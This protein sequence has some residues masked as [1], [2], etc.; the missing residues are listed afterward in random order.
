MQYGTGGVGRHPVVVGA[1]G[2]A[3]AGADE[4]QVLDAGD[5]ARVGTVQP[6]AGVGLGIER[7]QG[8]VGG[9]PC[10]QG[11]VLGLAAVA[12]VDAVGLRERRDVGDPLVQC[13]QAAAVRGFVLRTRDGIHPGTP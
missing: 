13:V 7:Q 10:D 6:A 11:V 8:A 2:V 5:V 4:G 1:G 9:H 12:P 3:V